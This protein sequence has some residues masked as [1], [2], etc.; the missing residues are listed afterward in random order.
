MRA[1]VASSRDVASGVLNAR[2]GRPRDALGRRSP[3]RPRRV[4]PVLRVIEREPSVLYDFSG[5]KPLVS[6]DGW[7]ETL[8]D[9]TPRK[10]GTARCDPSAR[11]GAGVRAVRQFWRRGDAS[12]YDRASDD[13]GVGEPSSSGTGGS[14]GASD[15]PVLAAL[16]RRLRDGT[17]PGSR[18]ASDTMKIGLAVEGGGMKGVVSAGACGELLRLGMYDCFDAVYGSS[19]G[20]M[21]LTYYLAKQPEGVAA[22][23]EDLVDGSFLDLRRLPKTKK[24]RR[25]MGTRRGRRPA[26]D[27]SYLVD[28]VMDG[29]TGR[30]L[31]WQDVLA[32]PLAFNVVATSLD[33][34]TP[35][36]LHSP[37]R[38]TRDLKTALKASAAVPLFAGPKP[39]RHRGQR[40]VD[41]AVMEP[42]PVHAAAAD[43]CTHVLVLLTRVL[44]RD[45]ASGD[46]AE[47]KEKKKK[48][49]FASRAFGPLVVAAVRGAFGD[50]VIGPDGGVDRAA[51]SKKVLGDTETHT[52]NMKTLESLVHPLVD[53]AREAF[54]RQAFE[55]KH[56]F[57]VLDIPLLFEKRYERTVDGVLV[58]SAGAE[59]QRERALARDGMTESKLKS[60]V[61]R[62][63]PDAEKIEK[64]DVVID[65]GCSKKETLKQVDEL[66]RS[67]R[68]GTGGFRAK[69][70]LNEA[71]A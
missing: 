58:V 62:Q 4:S 9:A 10:G 17:A 59:K 48:K 71:E 36:I 12:S 66:V 51:L 65:T 52:Q 37:F 42:V 16:A 6:P 34:L 49:S 24:S 38:D 29:I 46:D 57:V 56:A 1:A 3:R 5:E 14:V 13:D 55:D 23:Q 45:D 28:G 8:R 39:V 18:V 41:A 70:F 22:Y 67:I 21:N 2:P 31:R 26:M 32:S 68:A 35:V 60:I 33:T 19:A 40:L 20:A 27:V 43:G 47:T 7:M 30:A 15:H 44:D 11:P 25:L 61:A 53:S 64:A 54:L 50:E 69:T 63:T